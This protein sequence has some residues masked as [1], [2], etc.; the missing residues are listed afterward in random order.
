MLQA[1][2]S[3]KNVTAACG[4]RSLL[5]LVLVPIQ[6]A[7][8][9]SCGSSCRHF[10][11]VQTFSA[12]LDHSNSGYRWAICMFCI[13]IAY[14]SSA[15]V[16]EKIRTVLNSCRSF[17]ISPSVKVYKVDDMFLTLIVSVVSSL[18]LCITCGTSEVQNIFCS[19]LLTFWRKQSQHV[20]FKG[21][22]LSTVI[23]NSAN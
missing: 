10:S 1:A 16:K 11:M 13:C 12:Y 4:T 2:I 6:K 23:L 8:S 5:I 9:P 21:M 3:S 22:F 19:F 18:L 7:I 14:C 20:T 17:K 15:V